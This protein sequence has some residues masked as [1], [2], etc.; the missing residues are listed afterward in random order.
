VLVW[1]DPAGCSH[2]LLDACRERGVHFVVGHSP[3]ADIASV[4]LDVGEHGWISA[5]AD[6]LDEREDAHVPEITEW[7]DVSGGLRGPG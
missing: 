7:V 1:A 6:D 5:T 2:W 4:V 3:T